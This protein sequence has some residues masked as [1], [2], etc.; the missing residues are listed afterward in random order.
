MR[1]SASAVAVGAGRQCVSSTHVDGHPVPK[2]GGP[3]VALCPIWHL[4]RVPFIAL[5]VQ[6]SHMLE[7]LPISCF[8]I[9][10]I[11]IHPSIHEG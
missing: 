1:Y 2:V 9:N 4:Q 5:P 6:H 11:F 7:L 10:Q 3:G 8:P